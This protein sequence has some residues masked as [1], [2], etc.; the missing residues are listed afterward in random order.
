MT[1][2]RNSQIGLVN[3]LLGVC[4]MKVY[5]LYDKVAKKF[6]SLT[7]AESD[8]M[9]VRTCFAAIMMDYALNDVEFYCVGDFDDDLGII[10]PCVPRLCD[11]EC[12][13]FPESRLSKEKYL[14]TEQIVDMAQNKKSE[15]IKKTKDNIND[16]MRAKDMINAKI[17]IAEENKDKKTRKELLDMSKEIDEEINR[18]KEI[19]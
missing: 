7:L 12:Y 16:L 11:W 18:L 5:S 17:K 9:F 6:K 14:T 4:Q 2:M 1:N 19:A 15:F 10:K 8:Q 13:K 3:K